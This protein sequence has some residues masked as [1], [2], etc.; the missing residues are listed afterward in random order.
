[1]DVGVQ[2]RG[3]RVRE[4]GQ[5]QG[6]R[7]RVTGRRHGLGDVSSIPEMIQIPPTGLLPKPTEGL[8]P[9]VGCR[10]AATTPERGRKG[11]WPKQN[12]IKADSSL[13]N[14]VVFE[15]KQ[16]GVQGHGAMECC[17]GRGAAAHIPALEFRFGQQT[18]TATVQIR[19][20]RHRTAHSHRSASLGEIWA[21]WRAG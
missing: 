13:Q 1:M 3:D 7:N 5:R 10:R 2:A 4:L 21:A 16:V 8:S 9:N 19:P 11:A 12:K 17:T 18:L 14:P 20:P 6:R 15:I